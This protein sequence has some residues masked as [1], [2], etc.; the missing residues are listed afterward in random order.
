MTKIK[1]WCMQRQKAT[2]NKNKI[3]VYATPKSDQ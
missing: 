1:F 3:L 2:N